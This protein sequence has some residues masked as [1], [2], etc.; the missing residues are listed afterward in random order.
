[1][2]YK[3]DVRTGNRAQMVWRADSSMSPDERARSRGGAFWGNAYYANLRD[4]RVVAVDRDT[5][6]FIWDKQIARV[7]HPKYTSPNKDVEGLHRV[8]ARG[9]GEDS[10][11]PVEGRLRRQRLARRH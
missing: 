9:G 2:I 1:M 10:C 3:I 7:E 6:E 8:A 5:G 4:G 11:R